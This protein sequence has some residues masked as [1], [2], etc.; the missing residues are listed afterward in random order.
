MA[1]SVY[2][3]CKHGEKLVHL[4]GAKSTR[5][6]RKTASSMLSAASQLFLS[7]KGDRFFLWHAHMALIISIENKQQKIQN[8]LLV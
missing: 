3:V 4:G 6:I 8:I 2:E 1:A 5:A 7:E